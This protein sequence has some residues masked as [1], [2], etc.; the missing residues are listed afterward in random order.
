[1][2]PK[3]LEVGHTASRPASVQH[4]GNSDCILQDL[5]TTRKP[6]TALHLTDL[7]FP[8][9]SSHQNGVS[10]Q[11]AG[12][13]S[14]CKSLGYTDQHKDWTVVENTQVQCCLIELC[15]SADGRPHGLCADRILRQACPHIGQLVWS[16]TQT[17]TWDSM[18]WVHSHLCL[19]HHAVPSVWPKSHH[20]CSSLA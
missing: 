9:A 7:Q 4:S 2:T 5:W 10:Q 18:A 1:M 16:V 6:P 14:A 19:Q 13:V 11:T 8:K 17:C 3:H 15:I 20:P 12:P